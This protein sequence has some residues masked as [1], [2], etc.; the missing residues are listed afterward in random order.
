MKEL[1]LRERYD[2]IVSS[3]PKLRAGDKDNLYKLYKDV[4]EKIKDSLFTRTDM[5][6]GLADPHEELDRQ[7]NQRISLPLETENMISL[8]SGMNVKISKK[9]QVNRD[10]AIR[11]YRIAG[12]Y[13]GED[14]NV[15]RLRR[16]TATGVYKSEVPYSELIK[17]T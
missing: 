1:F 3:R 13:L 8:V 15:E 14:T 11:I 2:E 9:G 7:K 4:G 10:D 5:A 12:K 17:G 6:K 16:D